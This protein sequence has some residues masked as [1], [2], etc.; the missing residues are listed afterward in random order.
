M[1]F[2]PCPRFV[3][4]PAGVHPPASIESSG[5]TSSLAKLQMSSLL[6]AMGSTS[7]RR[8]RLGWTL[9]PLASIGSA[10]TTVPS[11]SIAPLAQ[12]RSRVPRRLALNRR[13]PMRSSS[14]SGLS[15][16]PATAMDSTALRRLRP[17][18]ASCSLALIGSVRMPVPS[19]SV[20]PLAQ[21]R[22]RV[23]LLLG[24]KRRTLMCPSSNSGSLKRSAV[25]RLERA[26]S[27]WSQVA[28]S[29]SRRLPYRPRSGLSR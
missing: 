13:V 2:R 20:A 1:R 19:S 17:D 22:S 26:L 28:P 3:V 11:S 10:R 15:K 16:C 6:A 12:S 23:Q 29:N 21:S 5:S 14:N 25:N 24:L 18:W 8:F 27:R 4:L 9:R 7:M